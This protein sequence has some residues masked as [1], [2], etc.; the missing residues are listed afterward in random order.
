MPAATL[1]VDSSFNQTVF[2]NADATLNATTYT[3]LTD[4]NG[5]IANG[6]GQFR[7][8]P[9][10]LAG[11]AVPINMAGGGYIALANGGANLTG[12]VLQVNLNVGSPDVTGTLRQGSLFY[13][14]EFGA[15]LVTPITVTIS[16][17]SVHYTMTV[18]PTSFSLDLFAA[19]FESQIKNGQSLNISFSMSDNLTADVS[20][21]IPGTTKNGREALNMSDRRDLGSMVGTY[22]TVYYEVPEPIPATLIGLGLALIG[23]VRWKKRR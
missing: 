17:G 7:N 22:I 5:N 2:G 9:V 23:V 13:R 18:D 20:G 14:P 1:V 21:Y 10:V 4:S 16:S 15:N 8:V 11:A 19:G 6:N 12:A 3:L